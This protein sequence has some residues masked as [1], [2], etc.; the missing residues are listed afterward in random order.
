[1][2]HKRPICIG[3]GLVALDVI[4][5]GSP[6][7]IPKIS[8]GGSCGNVLS[9]LSFLNWES[10]P[11]ARL[12]DN[13]ATGELLADMDRWHMNLRFLKINHEGSTPIIIHR[14]LKD[15]EGKPVHRFEFRD[16]ESKD[17]LPNFKGI[18]INFAKEIVQSDV[19]ADVFYFDRMN[20]GTLELAEYFRNKGTLIFF[21]PSSIKDEKLFLKCVALSH[22]VKFSGDRIND[23]QQRFP[24][25]QTDLEIITLGKNGLSYRSKR[26]HSKT[27]KTIKPFILDNVIDA[28][29]A[30]DWC[31]AGIISKIGIGGFNTLNKAKI[32]QIKE[33]LNYGQILGSLNCI[34]DGARGLM[35][36][37]NK[38]KISTLVKKTDTAKPR[39]VPDFAIPTE[40]LID[41]SKQIQI[42][43]LY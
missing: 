24:E 9:I 39:K 35:Y 36:Q 19:K 16:P 1:M 37:F 7:T 2:A 33:A 17:W 29:G 28:A 27:W 34:F 12:A 30:G 18:T 20:P 41:I 22:V 4:L 13:Q 26:S 14:I 8:V 10:M 32:S 40:S 23:Y 11:I 3:A 21:E 38:A 6:K 42:S 5:N 31:S 43:E 15:R 25:A